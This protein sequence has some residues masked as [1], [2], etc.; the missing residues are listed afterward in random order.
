MELG[1]VLTVHR[2][3]GAEWDTVIAVLPKCRILERSLVYTALSRCKARC[4]VVTDDAAAL[5]YAVKS[6]SVYEQ[7]RDRLFQING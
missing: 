4:I 2:A 1:Y 5:F 6:E 3:Q 7:R